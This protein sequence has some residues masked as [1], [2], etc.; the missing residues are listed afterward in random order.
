MPNFRTLAYVFTVTLATP[1]F[2]IAQDSVTDGTQATMPATQETQAGD[3]P[4]KSSPEEAITAVSERIDGM[5][6]KINE[7]EVDVKGLKKLKISGYIQARYEAH[8][9]AWNGLDD[10]KSGD[11]KTGSGKPGLADTFYI[12]RGRVKFA[13]QAN[14]WSEGVVYPDLSKSGVSLKDAYVDLKEQWTKTHTLRMGQFNIPYG[15]EIEQSSSNRELPERSRWERTVF[16]GERDRGAAIYGKVSVLRYAAA[17]LNG[18]GIE[19]KDGNFRGVDNNFRKQYVGRAGFDAGWLVAGVSGSNNV[20][21]VPAVKAI[22]AKSS[23]DANFNGVIDA[24]EINVSKAVIG[25]PN[26]QYREDAAGLYLMYFQDIPYLGGFSLKGEYNRGWTGVFAKED[27][28]DSKP[29]L[30]PERRAKMLGWHALVSQFVGNKN[31]LVYRIDQFDGDLESR[32]KDCHTK[33]HADTDFCHFSRI[34]THAVAW[35]FFWDGNVRL[36]T[37]LEVPHQ[38]VWKDKKDA[39]F[40]EQVQYKF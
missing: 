6:E 24:K 26:K 23:G 16:A 2:A 35:N 10:Q 5:Q 14:D 9:D 13:F 34:T 25:T 31:Q 1:S 28:G 3:P 8:Q 29:G 20:K 12:R 32:D 27:G 36:T 38:P 7:I 17:V 19:D 15:Y 30:N 40:T 21:L 37:A 33:K 39:T 11:F 18:N 4:A 22:R